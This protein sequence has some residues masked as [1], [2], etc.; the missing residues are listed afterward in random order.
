MIPKEE[1]S[2]RPHPSLQLIEPEERWPAPPTLTT[3]RTQEVRAMA[4]ISPITVARFWSKVAVTAGNSDC[5]IWRG[6]KNGNGYGNFRMPDFGR[7]N[8]AAHRVAYLIVNGEW[9]PEGLL[10]RHKCDTPLCVNP[11]HLEIGTVA[12]NMRDMYE[13]GR[14]VVRD[15]RG[16]NNGAA[17]LNEAQ[18]SE[19]KEL[20]ASGHTNTSI[21][22]RFGVSHQLISRIRG[23]KAWAA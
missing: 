3:T 17:K 1:S 13:R 5:W 18:V 8:F 2:C 9:P 22:A 19:I 11:H 7:A 20:I 10:I 16:E 21:A 12:D 15:Q 23:G 6:A 14:N 4:G